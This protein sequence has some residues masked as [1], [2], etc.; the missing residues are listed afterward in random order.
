M[1]AASS[2]FPAVARALAC[3]LLAACCAS[4]ATA[5]SLRELRALAQSEPQGEKH[6][7]TQEA[8]PAEPQGGNYVNY[9]LVGVMEGVIEAHDQDVRAGAAPVICLNSRRLEPRM[10]KGLYDGELRRHADLYEADMPVPLVL[11]Q[12]L[13][14]AYPCDWDAGA[15]P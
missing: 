9:Y 13:A 3:V 5:M 8:K 7:E 11:F 2:S 15:R 14:S 6:G 10:A 4:A 12:A 1:P